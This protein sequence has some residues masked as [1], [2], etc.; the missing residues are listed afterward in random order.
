MQA[1]V[2][3]LDGVVTDTA[4][5]HF[6]AWS[7]LAK[8]E[9]NLDLPASF[10][11]NLKGISRTESLEAILKFGDLLDKY[12]KEEVQNLAN[13]KNDYYVEAIS[14]LTKEDILPGISKLLTDLKANGVKLAVASASKNAPF[15]LEKLGLAHVFDAVADPAKV[16]AG[17]P[18]PDIFL[19]GAKAVG[20]APN[21]CVGVEDAVA[22][23]S[24][25]KAA[26]M[27]AVAVGDKN[28]LRQADCVV[29][30]TRNFTYQLFSDVFDRY[31]K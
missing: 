21:Q 5:F 22:G 11:T 8:E 27:V 2:F 16:K 25:I 10:E 29:P 3:D 19:A 6:Q 7:K 18:A 9:F 14:K 1:A 12:S 31:H 17:K 15:I 30:T 23:V 24:A 13:K 4:K 26:D 28:E 20:V